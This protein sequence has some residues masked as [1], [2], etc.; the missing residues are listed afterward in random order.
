MRW[1][2]PSVKVSWAGTM[3]DELDH[4]RRLVGNITREQM[5]H[6][7]WAL[8]R[9]LGVFTPISGP[10]FYAISPAHTHPAYAFVLSFDGATLVRV[11][12]ALLC[13]P[14]GFLSAMA[15]GIPHQEVPGDGPP[16]YAAVLIEPRYFRA[17]L[18]DYPERGGLPPLRGQSWPGNPEL[19]RAVKDLLAEHEV[20]LP[21]RTRVLEALALRLTHQIA[22]CLLGVVAPSPSA[23]HRMNVSAAVEFFHK[24]I[25]R[26]VAV[27]ELAH[28]AH[29]SVSHFSRLFEQDLGL[30][31][32]PYMLK[33]RLSYAKRL[34]L[35]GEGN[36]T[37]VALACGFGSS[38]HFTGAFRRAFGTTPSAYRKLICEK[39]I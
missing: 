14:P 23:A 33:A 10:C 24:N 12:D 17:V 32:K 20:A 27:S 7:D 36:I 2:L 3:P 6:V 25:G 19:V 8:T 9:H 16:R 11:A 1:N 31:P 13:P 29:L 15:P 22:R 30:R 21:G 5:R 18:A 26:A 35:Q 39:P 34:L 4:I 38:A 28:A 37:E